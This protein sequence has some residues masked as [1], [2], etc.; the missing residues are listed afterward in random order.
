MSLFDDAA[1]ASSALGKLQL[2]QP[3]LGQS[4]PQVAGAAPVAAP[5]P[6][7]TSGNV[8]PSQAAANGFQQGMSGGGSGILGSIAKGAMQAGV[9]ALMMSDERVKKEVEPGAKPVQRFMD[10]LRAHEYRYKNPEQPGAGKGKFVSPMAQELEDAGPV[11]KSMVEDTPDGK[12]VNYG[13]GL[14]TMLAAQADMHQRL[15][16]LEGKKPKE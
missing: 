15:K 12:M 7:P 9:S 16:Q 4:L 5:A 8:T 13:R 3:T 2:T 1:A 6:A 14:A 11:G 10:K